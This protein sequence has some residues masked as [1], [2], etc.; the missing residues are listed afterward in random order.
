MQMHI[1]GRPDHADLGFIRMFGSLVRMNVPTEVEFMEEVSVSTLH[2]ACQEKQRFLLAYTAW[3]CHDWIMK[4][5]QHKNRLHP[6]R[7]I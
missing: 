5:T 4:S 2:S 7:V 1:T 3:F 6:L